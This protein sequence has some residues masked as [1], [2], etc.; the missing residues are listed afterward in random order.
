MRNCC[1]SF[2]K[3]TEFDLSEYPTRHGVLKSNVWDGEH[4]SI[5]R[6][7]GWCD[8]EDGGYKIDSNSSP[9]QNNKDRPVLAWICRIV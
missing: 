4:R 9:T 3:K 6:R 7:D 8:N 1:R 5:D 2:V